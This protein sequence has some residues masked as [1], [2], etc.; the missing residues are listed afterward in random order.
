MDDNIVNFIKKSLEYYDN[1]TNENKMYLENT[2]MELTR[3]N[4]D[5]NIITAN[6]LYKII[7]DSNVISEGN[8]ELLG[9]FDFQTKI[10]ISGWA[11]MMEAGNIALNSLSR[12]L[13]DYVYNLQ[14]NNSSYDIALYKYIHNLLINSRILIED[15]IEL[16]IYL[17][18]ISYL[19]KNK[20]KFI[21]PH[22]IYINTDKT[23]YVINYYLIL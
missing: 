15:S 2:K 4:Y 19:L 5:N 21:Y 12:E 13:F 18:S 10:W 6:S 17:A 16:D 11:I 14:L 8:Y 1:Q 7:K 23:K 9:I 22:I 3:M 20:I